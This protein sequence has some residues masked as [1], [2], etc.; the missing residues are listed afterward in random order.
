VNL[1]KAVNDNLM[2]ELDETDAEISK[3]A[4]K[5]QALASQYARLVAYAAL[6]K[7][8]EEVEPMSLSKTET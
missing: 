1:I 3:T 4:E 8:F 5:L 7:A 6:N 2:A